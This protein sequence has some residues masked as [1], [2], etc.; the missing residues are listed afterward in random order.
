MEA[1]SVKGVSEVLIGQ[2]I[3]EGILC[4]DNIEECRLRIAVCVVLLDHV[5]EGLEQP[6][7]NHLPFALLVWTL[8]LQ[9]RHL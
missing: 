4:N 1:L 7:C 6:Y 9:L 2:D 8:P 3:A 5:H